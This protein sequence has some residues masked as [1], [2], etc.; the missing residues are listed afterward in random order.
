MCL[1]YYISVKCIENVSSCINIL[2]IMLVV[3]E[4]AHAC[5]L[6]IAYCMIVSVIIIIHRDRG[7]EHYNWRR[8]GFNPNHWCCWRLST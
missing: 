7:E 6:Y 3:Y 2:M 5:I 8:D 1:A 4:G